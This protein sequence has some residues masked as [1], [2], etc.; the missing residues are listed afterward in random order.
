MLLNNL[1]INEYLFYLKKTE[2]N[3]LNIIIKIVEEACFSYNKKLN[4]NNHS[5]DNKCLLFL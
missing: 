1:E 2:W 5:S 3:L 4:Y